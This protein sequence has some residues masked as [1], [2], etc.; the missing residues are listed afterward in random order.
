LTALFEEEAD[1]V[2]AG[3]DGTSQINK[4]AEKRLLYFYVV[5]ETLFKSKETSHDYV[6]A[7][8]DS[9]HH[10]IQVFIR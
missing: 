10:W 9:L 5:N 4:V 8:G 1:N 3:I 7:F 6:K 2:Q